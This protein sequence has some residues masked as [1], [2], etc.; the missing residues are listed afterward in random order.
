MLLLQACGFAG[1][2]QNGKLARIT[3]LDPAG[4]KFDNAKPE[5]RLTSSDAQ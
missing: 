2:N 4:L 3:G 1:K 5:N